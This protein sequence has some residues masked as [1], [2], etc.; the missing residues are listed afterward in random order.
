MTHWPDQRRALA[1]RAGPTVS[2]GK[3]SESDYIL[4]SLKKILA[5]RL[6]LNLKLNL[7]PV[8]QVETEG[9]V[10]CIVNSILISLFV[11]QCKFNFFVFKVQFIASWLI[12]TIQFMTLNMKHSTYKGKFFIMKISYFHVVGIIFHIFLWW[13]GLRFSFDNFPTGTLFTVSS[14]HLVF[15]P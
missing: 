12:V 14:M 8:W 2:G 1:N 6:S 9:I 7:L 10:P 15:V 3:S 4:K 11:K 5:G 13:W